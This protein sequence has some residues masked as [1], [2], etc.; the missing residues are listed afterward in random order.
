MAPLAPFSRYRADVADRPESRSGA[1]AIVG[2]GEFLPRPA[3]TPL[4]PAPV[5]TKCHAMHG[6]A[7]GVRFTGVFAIGVP[8]ATH[9]SPERLNGLSSPGF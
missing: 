3:N 7:Q 9:L 2:T 8:F 5:H 4:A 6:G 1:L